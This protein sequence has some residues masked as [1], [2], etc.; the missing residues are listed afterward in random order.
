MATALWTSPYAG[1]CRSTAQLHP[2]VGVQRHAFAAE[3]R[4]ECVAQ[5]ERMVLGTG[6]VIVTRKSEGSSERRWH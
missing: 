1:R 6:E 3:Q 2:V 4:C 5:P